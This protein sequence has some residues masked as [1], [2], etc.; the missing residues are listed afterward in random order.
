MEGFCQRPGGVSPWRP[1]RREPS[2]RQAQSSGRRRGRFGIGCPGEAVEMPNRRRPG[3][4]AR[5]QAWSDNQN[6]LQASLAGRRNQSITA[7]A[8]ASFAAPAATDFG[9]R[10]RTSK[11]K[12]QS[13]MKVMNRKSFE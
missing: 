2:T 7:C 10:M 9:E 3:P 12:A 8:A 4:L 11:G 6:F 5:P 1:E 13:E